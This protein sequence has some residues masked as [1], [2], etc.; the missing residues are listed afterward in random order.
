MTT[1]HHYA[2]EPDDADTELVSVGA[3]DAEIEDCGD[4]AAPTACRPLLDNLR[5]ANEDVHSLRNL[6]QEAR[7]ASYNGR[8]IAAVRSFNIAFYWV[9]TVPVLTVAF[10]LLWAFV[11]RPHRA[12]TALVIA[13]FLGPFL[14]AL[15]GFAVPDGLDVTTWSTSNWQ[16]AGGIALVLVVA[17]AVALL[18]E[19]RR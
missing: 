15:V 3:A 5:F 13:F 19:R 18:G 14:N 6:L 11:L 8:N 10:F 2:I 1:S 7:G 16:W 17:T 4:E 12:V 9:I